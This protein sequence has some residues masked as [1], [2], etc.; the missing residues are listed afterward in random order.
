M[1]AG[2]TTIL[3]RAKLNENVATSPTIG[4]NVETVSPVEGVSLTV[5]DV[6]GGDRMPGLW[7][8]YYDGVEGA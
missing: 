1:A 7:H 8:H 3:Y 4:F 5:W 6:G 2:K